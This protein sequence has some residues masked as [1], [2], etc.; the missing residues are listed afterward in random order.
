MKNMIKFILLLLSF[1]VYANETG[2]FPFAT[3][4]K[5]L[6]LVPLQTSKIIEG[7]KEDD[8]IIGDRTGSKIFAK[9]GLNY[10]VLNGGN[11]QVYFSLCSTKIIDQKISVIENFNPKH[12][13]LKIFCAHHKIFPEQISIIHKEFKNQPVTYV[14]IKGKE[15]DTA[16][17]LMGNI[18][19]KVSD[20]IL[21][22]RF[23]LS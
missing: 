15:S 3:S 9:G 7:T 23:K 20:V 13:S 16:I 2:Y 14:H 21:N 22:E 8:Y 6:K 4:A 10:I 17:A 12:D 1:T 19:L 18:D 5:E 11:N